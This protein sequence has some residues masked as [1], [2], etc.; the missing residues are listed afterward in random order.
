M[1]SFSTN[2]HVIRSRRT[3]FRGPRRNHTVA[4]A[5]LPALAAKLR[6][7]GVGLHSLLVYGLQWRRAHP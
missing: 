7:R 3:E 4:A 2:A 5:H 1:S 6:Q